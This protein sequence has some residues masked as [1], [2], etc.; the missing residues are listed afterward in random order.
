MIKKQSNAFQGGEG[1]A[2]YARNQAYLNSASTTPDVTF[3]EQQLAGFAGRINRVVEV[4]CGNGLKLERLCRA[5]DAKGRGFDPS[6]AAVS[7]GNAWL[8][9]CGAPVELAVGTADA[10]PVQDGDCD[11]FYFGFCLY[12]ID[13]IDL[14]KVVAEAH[15][16]VAPG[17]FIAIYDFDP[18]YRHSRPYQHLEGLYSFKQNYAELFLASGMYSVVGKIS[19]SHADQAFCEDGDERV[20]VTILYKQPDAYPAWKA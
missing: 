9:E 7:D 17:G 5:F 1:D 14:F 19:F 15:R 2:W 18:P 3:V 10:L 20:A 6:Q 8:L 12:L 13:R 4:G 16:T 11:L